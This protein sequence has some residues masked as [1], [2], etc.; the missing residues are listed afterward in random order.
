VAK[1]N[2]GK[3]SKTNMA[4]SIKTNCKITSFRHFYIISGKMVEKNKKQKQKQKTQIQINFY[5][6]ELLVIFDQNVLLSP[7]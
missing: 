6:I 3:M 4:W 5:L 2:R 7:N 1:H